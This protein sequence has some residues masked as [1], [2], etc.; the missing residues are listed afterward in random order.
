M[1]FF[2][3]WEG[4]GVGRGRKSGCVGAASVSDTGKGLADAREQRM[5][6]CPR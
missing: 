3:K 6:H 5:S 2:V 1:T 4:E